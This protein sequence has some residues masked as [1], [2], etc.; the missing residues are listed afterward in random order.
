MDKIKLEKL[1][2]KVT[3]EFNIKFF[4]GEINFINMCE[5]KYALDAVNSKAFENTSED[6]IDTLLSKENS[7]EVLY[8]MAVEFHN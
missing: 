3:K 8:E 4:N 1:R 7:L 2:N 5:W 6:I